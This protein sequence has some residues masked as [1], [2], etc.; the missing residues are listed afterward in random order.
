M[1]GSAFSSLDFTWQFRPAIGPAV[2][3]DNLRIIGP[4]PFVYNEWRF[5][6]RKLAFFARNR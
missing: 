4:F 2:N 3:S 1:A 6:W 5:L